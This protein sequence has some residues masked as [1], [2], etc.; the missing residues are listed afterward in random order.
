M[1]CLISRTDFLW[2]EALWQKILQKGMPGELQLL[3]GQATLTFASIGIGSWSQ[4]EGGCTELPAD[5]LPLCLLPCAAVVGFSKAKRCCLRRSNMYK[6][7]RHVQAYVVAEV[8]CRVHSLLQL[9][10]EVDSAVRGT[11]G[12]RAAMCVFNRS[13]HFCRCSCC[14]LVILS[15]V[16]DGPS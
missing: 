16:V 3:Y 6:P 8:H 13:S 12:V 14:V 7:G 15:C 10:Q 1:Q 11:E 9:L 4:S 5:C 2:F